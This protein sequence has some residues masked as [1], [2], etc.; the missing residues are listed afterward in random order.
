MLDRLDRFP[1]GVLSQYFAIDHDNFSIAL[2]S[3]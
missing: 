2:I 1:D 3:L